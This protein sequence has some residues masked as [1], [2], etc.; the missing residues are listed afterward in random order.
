MAEGGLRGEP[1]LS[2]LLG[3]VEKGDSLASDEGRRGCCGRSDAAS[4][5]GST[6]LAM[7]V[8]LAG[9]FGFSALLTGGGG[10]AAVVP[11]VFKLVDGV[12]GG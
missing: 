7:V 9:I 6:G 3:G 11:V 5:T 1:G 2:S 4:G 10:F 12:T 8:G